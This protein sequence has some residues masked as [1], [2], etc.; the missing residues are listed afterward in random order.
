M[1]AIW[2]GRGLAL[3]MVVV[4]LAGVTTVFGAEDAVKTALSD[5]YALMHQNRTTAELNRLDL[6]LLHNDIAD[7]DQESSKIFTTG[8]YEQGFNNTVTRDVTPDEARS[9]LEQEKR[10]QAREPLVR[11]GALHKAIQSLLLSKSQL[12]TETTL[13]TLTREEVAIAEAR[14]K[15][16]ILSAADLE[17]AKA[18]ITSA[19]LS[20]KKL[21]LSV[22]AAELEINRLAGTD[23]DTELASGDTIVLLSSTFA[24][25]SA[26]AEWEEMAKA[27]DPAVFAKSEALRLLDRKLEI[28]KNFIPDTHS[29]TVQLRRDR[30]DTRL[31]LKDT[32]D[33][34]VVNLRNGLN[35]RLTA[36]ENL[37]L[38]LLDQDIA[39][40]KQALAKARYDAGVA[41]KLD[42]IAAEKSV[43]QAQQSVRSATVALNRVE[44]ELRVL[45]GLPLPESVVDTAT[46]VDGNQTGVSVPTEA[47]IQTTP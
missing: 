11:E 16:G 34:I 3:V 12:Q 25:M 19:E 22:D 27:A 41:N 39:R 7:A 9:R 43:V 20:L 37:E 32:E 15:A 45:V 4:L 24:D 8:V 5:L 30:E 21:Q 6:L 17:D 40:R 2:K 1:K 26:L 28:A 14:F 23:L 35:D 38:A 36:V 18:A 31:A 44:T 13:L 42:L 10:S 29:R 47:A 46:T 33:G